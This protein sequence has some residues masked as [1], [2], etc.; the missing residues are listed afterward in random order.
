LFGV[1]VGD[2][3]LAEELKGIVMYIPSKGTGIFPSAALL[4]L[5]C[6]SFFSAFPHFSD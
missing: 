4:F 1:G 6:S 5:V 3:V 2:L